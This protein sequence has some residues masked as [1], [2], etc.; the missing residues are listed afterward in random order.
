VPSGL[1]LKVFLAGRVAVEADGVLMGEERFPGRQGRLL[2]ACLVA[3]QGRP[4]PRDELAEALWGEAPPATWEKALT[5]LVSK[6]RVLLAECGLDAAK[7]LSS[8]FGCYRLNLPEGTWVDVIAAADAVAEAEAALATDDLEHAR[9]VAMRAAALARPPFLPG[10]EGAWVE[11][12]RREFTDIL[13]RALSCLAEACLRSSDE[14]EAARWAEE[15]IALEPYRET[16]YRQLMAAH[17]AAGN[18][19]EALRVYERCRQLF[20][21]ELGAYPSPETESIYRE[22]LGAPS[23]EPEAAAPEAAPVPVLEGAP[24][25]VPARGSR[26]LARAVERIE[27]ARFGGPR[28]LAFVSA[29]GNRSRGTARGRSS[30]RPTSPLPPLRPNEGSLLRDSSARGGGCPRAHA[31]SHRPS[32]LPP[33]TRRAA[34]PMTHP[35]WQLFSRVRDR[36]RPGLPPPPPPRQPRR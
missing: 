4:V 29:A 19:A 31:A 5:V 1:D 34:E 35:A 32:P 10:E 30:P 27:G 33:R 15:T 14:A 18:R 9:A 17:A 3:E 22:L 12:Q 20:A 2:F 26:R 23:P 13:R 11:G 36:P 25:T 6:L 21:T 7:V 16:G 28:H 8:A 24:E